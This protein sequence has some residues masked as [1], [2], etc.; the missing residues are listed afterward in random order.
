VGFGRLRRAADH[1]GDLGTLLIIVLCI[2]F[3]ILV[4]GI[5]FALGVRLLLWGARLL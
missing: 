5:P 4:I 1:I 2:P 3:L